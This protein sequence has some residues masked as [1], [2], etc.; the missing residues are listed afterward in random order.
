MLRLRRLKWMWP[1]LV[2][3]GAKVWLAVLYSMGDRPCWSDLTAVVYAVI[4]VPLLGPLWTQVRLTPHVSFLARDRALREELAATSLSPARLIA[5]HLSL[6]LAAALLPWAIGVG[7][8]MPLIVPWREHGRLTEIVANGALEL[9]GQC[10]SVAWLL[11]M[12]ARQCRRRAGAGSM[13]LGF[14]AFVLMEL[15]AVGLNFISF[16]YNLDAPRGVLAVI[17]LPPSLFILRAGWREA[18]RAV[19]DFQQ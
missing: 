10:V 14:A 1:D 7:L 19:Y 3:S 16:E 9:A 2:L 11:F 12:L 17:V 15:A 5:S 4:L 8:A 13:M 6:P 18:C